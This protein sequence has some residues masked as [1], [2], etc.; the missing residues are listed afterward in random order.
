MLAMRFQDKR[1]ALL[2]ESGFD[3]DITQLGL[4]RRMQM[5]FRLL[6]SQN[7]FFRSKSCDEHRKNLT[8]ADADIAMRYSGVGAF[9]NENE[10][11]DN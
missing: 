2:A 4:Q 11:F 8:H 6:D 7:F 3:E 1:I 5:N 10:F 9:V